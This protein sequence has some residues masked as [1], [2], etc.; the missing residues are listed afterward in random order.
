MSDLENCASKDELSVHQTDTLPSQTVSSHKFSPS[1]Q[2]SIIR[3]VDVRLVLTLGA[4]YCVSLMD[5]TNLG[6]ASIAG[7]IPLL[8]MQTISVLS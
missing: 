8:S 2:S 7:Y 5:R 4:M 1:E 3:R 6:F